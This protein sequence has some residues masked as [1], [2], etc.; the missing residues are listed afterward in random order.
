MKLR[1]DLALSALERF[2]ASLRLRATEVAWGICD[3]VNENMAS[4]ARIHIAE[5]GHDPREFSL[6]ATGGAGPVHAVEVARKLQIP[7]VL[8]TIAAGAGSCLGLLAA[9]ARVDRAWSNPALVKDIE[10]ARVAR[11]YGELRADAENELV[12]AG[13][14]VTG[15]QWVIGAEMRYAGQGHNVSVSLP[16][17]NVTAAM[18]APLLQEFEK[19]YRQLYGH[20]VPGAAPQV[21]TWRLT[22]RSRVRSHRFN[23]GDA[24]VSA[25]PVLRDKRQIWLPQK[26]RYGAVAVYDRYSLKPGTHLEGPVVLEERE[27]TLVVP[28]PADVRVLADYT[29][30][31]TIA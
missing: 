12:S 19:R 29:V 5:K 28:V 8:A 4:A 26:R 23:W 25:R 10:W 27:S 9:P 31:V 11:V 7:R 14:T 18:K 2:A 17:R 24:R 1:R 20:L 6:V 22:G 13:A 30:S 21:V 15:L 16:W 3:I